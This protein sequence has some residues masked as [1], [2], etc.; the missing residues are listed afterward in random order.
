[1]GILYKISGLSRQCYF[2][3][4]QR[5]EKEHYYRQRTVEI[6]NAVRKEHPQM[7]ARTMH[8]MLKINM[9]GINKF[10]RLV[11]ESG[12][13]IRKKQLWI[14]T[15]HSNHNYY[16]WS[17]LTYG[18]KL[19]GI[20]QLW[21]SDITYWII[22]NEVFY[23]VLIQDV[24]SRRILGYTASNNMYTVNNLR[25]LEMAFKER[26]CSRFTTLIHHSD[27]G[28]QYCSAGYT[29]ELLQ[30]GIKIS[31]ANNSIE[32]P[33]AERLNGIIKNDYLK[34][35][36]TDTLGQLNKSLDKVVRLY[37]H[38]KP[39]SE[40]GYMSPIDYERKLAETPVK[41]REEMVLYDFQKN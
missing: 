13:G 36:Q 3:Q 27:K 24:Y 34:F 7:G 12:L 14:K 4:K 28:S 37:N 18:L 5:H 15:T 10:E 8:Y 35:Y 33:Y 29:N 17:N 38:Q 9:F 11:S 6:V 32:N 23:I 41:Q 1:M 16:T 30:A 19:N 39:H 26:N 25:S 21:V 2:Q 22:E 31:M 20:N 40:L